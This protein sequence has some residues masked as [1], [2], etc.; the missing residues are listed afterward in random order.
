L[1]LGVPLIVSHMFV[2]YFGIMAD[3]TPPVA[4]AAFAAAPIAKESGMRI[5][6]NA[7]RIAA[8]GF[9]VPYMAVYTPALMLQDGGPLAQAIGYWPAVAYVIAKA[10]LAIGMWGMATVGHFRT[11]LTVPERLWAFIAAAFLV[12]ALPL[13]DEIGFAGC[14][15]FLAWHYWRTRTAPAPAE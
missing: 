11:R 15:G 12:A 14:L 6:V 7:V 1:S 8:A 2:F 4:L 9:I 5:G 13:T 3:L 10:L